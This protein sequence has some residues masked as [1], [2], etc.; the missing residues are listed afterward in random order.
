[1]NVYGNLKTMIFNR[2][3]SGHKILKYLVC[4]VFT[5]FLETI[6]GWLFLHMTSCGIVVA[7]TAAVL[8]GALVHYFITLLIVFEKRN[9]AK[10]FLIYILSFVLGLVLQN[11]IIWLFYEKI[12]FR[13]AEFWKYTVSKGMSLVVPFFL[14]YVIRKRLNER[15]IGYD[16]K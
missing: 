16:F 12:L 5:A 1:M 6:A 13:A 15:I 11:A 3:K 7:N 9:N 14:L 2:I 8:M 4:S 10:S